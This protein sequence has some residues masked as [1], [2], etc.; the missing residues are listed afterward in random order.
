MRTSP[1]SEAKEYSAEGTGWT[2][3]EFSSL[4]SKKGEKRVILAGVSCFYNLIIDIVELKKNHCFLNL[5]TGHQQLASPKEL[6][7]YRM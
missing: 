7:V 2:I 4:K 5:V 3:I 6:P 1:N